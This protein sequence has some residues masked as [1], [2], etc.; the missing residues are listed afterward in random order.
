MA[1]HSLYIDITCK[2]FNKYTQKKV[3]SLYNR[4]LLHFETVSA[5][6]IQLLSVLL[7]S[8]YFYNPLNSIRL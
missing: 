1:F 3:K 7:P 8:V 2:M 5:F 6:S 4:T